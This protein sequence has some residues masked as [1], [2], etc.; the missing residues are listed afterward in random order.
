MRS[1]IIQLEEEDFQTEGTDQSLAKGPGG[2]MQPKRNR[3][4]KKQ[5]GRKM[6]PKLYRI[7]KSAGTLRP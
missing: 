6:V 5:S 7:L 2:P 4:N 1:Q 3:G